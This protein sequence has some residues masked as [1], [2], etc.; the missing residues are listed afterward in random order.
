MTIVTRTAT[1][2]LGLCAVASLAACGSDDATTATPSTVTVTAS[3]PSTTTSVDAR[4]TDVADTAQSG[5]GSDGG[6]GGDVATPAPT[7]DRAPLR[8]CGTTNPA[9]AE[10]D[11]AIASVPTDG[12]GYRWVTGAANFDSC[13][14]ISY[15][16][17]DTQ[18]AT[19]SSPQQLLIFNRDMRF[20][21]TGIKCNVGYQE[22]I[23]ASRDRITVQ[24]RY[25]TGDEPLAAPQGSTQVTFRWNGSRVV[26]DGSLPRAVT[27][28]KC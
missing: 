27:N 5:S 3:P 11:R 16:E 2:V 17:L 23:G 22:V 6:S 14:D 9:P 13:N 18:G 15:M 12:P 1:T 25:L 4:E 21:G 24:Y 8:R 28:G 26:M 20:I 10:L 19:V 7:S